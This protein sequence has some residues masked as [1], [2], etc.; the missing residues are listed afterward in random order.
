M[1]VS[2]G[3]C[4]KHA[5]DKILMCLKGLALFSVFT[6]LR[7]TMKNSGRAGSGQEDKLQ[8]IIKNE[9]EIRL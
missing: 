5:V 9:K 8:Q 2:A 4:F 3:N 7:R 6:P 1:A